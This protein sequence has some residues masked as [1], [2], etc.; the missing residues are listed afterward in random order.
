MGFDIQPSAVKDVVTAV[1]KEGLDLQNGVDVEKI[2]GAVTGLVDVPAPGV[3]QAVA[4]GVP[5]K[6]VWRAVWAALELPARER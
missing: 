4:E 3:A 2:N 5:V 1:K 6:T